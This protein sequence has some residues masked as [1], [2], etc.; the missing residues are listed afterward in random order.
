MAEFLDGKKRK[1]H[2]QESSTD[3]SRTI[4]IV[5]G[6]I[7]VVVISVILFLIN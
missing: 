4:V 1:K 6:V 7:F 2:V 3:L 5:V